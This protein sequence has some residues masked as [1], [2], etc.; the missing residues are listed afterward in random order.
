MVLRES[1]EMYLETIYVLSRERDVVRAV[2]IAN[3]MSFSKPTISEWMGKLSEG[4]Y[5]TIDNGA[6]H[7]TG[8]GL[9]IAQKVYE[10]HVTLEEFLQ[11]MGI[12]RKTAEEDACRIEHY[13]SDSTFEAIKAYAATM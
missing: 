8:E 4:G 13:I 6:I 3:R 11:K 7:L 12:D 9:A 10:R 2:D 5:V 1:A